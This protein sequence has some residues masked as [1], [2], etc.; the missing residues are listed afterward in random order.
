[1]KDNDL[2]WFIKSKKQLLH[3]PV[4]DV[5]QQHEIAA[6]GIEGDYIALE[7][8]DWVTVI[9]EYRGKFVMVRQWRHSAEQLTVEFPGGVADRGEDPMSAAARELL[10]ETGFKAGSM[11][12]LGTCNPNPA[13]NKN[14]IHVFLAGELE[15]TGTQDLDD[16]ELLTCRLIPIG[17]VIASFG[18]GEFTH[19]FTGTALAYYLQYEY[20]KHKE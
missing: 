19:A 12:H 15:P 9:P 16:D 7:A 17:D 1:M 8:P 11:I 2:K 10:E 13:L 3:T 18:K 14:N 4:Y 6:N 20:L 5:I